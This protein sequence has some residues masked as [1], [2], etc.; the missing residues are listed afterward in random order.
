MRRWQRASSLSSHGHAI[1][2]TFV[3]GNLCMRLVV[4]CPAK[5]LTGW[6][7]KVRTTYASLSWVVR[8]ADLW[9]FLSIIFVFVEGVTTTE[10][11]ADWFSCRY[12]HT[13]IQKHRKIQMCIDSDWG[14]YERNWVELRPFSTKLQKVLSL[15]FLLER[16]KLDAFVF[17]PIKNCLWWIY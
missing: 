8:N 1:V 10:N 13:H 16:R 15:F 7:M 17:K 11:S 6:A 5:V 12:M 14:K 3:L 9:K 4:V 2:H